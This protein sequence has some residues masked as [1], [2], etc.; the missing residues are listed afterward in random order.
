MGPVMES[1]VQKQD[2]SIIK[3]NDKVIDLTTTPKHQDIVKNT[4]LQTKW[5]IYNPQGLTE[6]ENE[7][8]YVDQGRNWGWSC[9]FGKRQSP[10]NLNKTGLF[11]REWVNHDVSI[12]FGYKP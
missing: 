3:T 4:K 6:A 10:I 8:D 12:R 7:W 1:P 5:E 2:K 11:R 9:L